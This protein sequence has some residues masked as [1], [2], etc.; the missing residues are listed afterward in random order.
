[1]NAKKIGE[2]LRKLRGKTPVVEFAKKLGVSPS[3][4]YM[5]ETGERVP[6]DVTK[7]KYAKIFKTTVDKLFFK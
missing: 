5:Y 4:I 7:S 2:K 3:A 1:M 6:N